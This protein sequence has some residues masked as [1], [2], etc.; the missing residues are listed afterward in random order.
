MTPGSMSATGALI[1]QATTPRARRRRSEAR[2]KLAG[3]AVAYLRVSTEEQ[4]VSGLGLDAQREA[5]EAVAASRGLTIVEWRT[6]AGVSG[7]TIGKRP[8]FLDALRDL[9]EGRAGVLLSK[10]ATRL[11][12]SLTDLG[13][14]LAAATRDGWAVITADGLVDT[15]DPKGRLLPMFLGIVGELERTF[16]QQRTKAALQAAKARGVTLGK[17]SLL[18][19]EV[20]S[21]IVREREAGSTW[22]GIADSLNS[23]GVPTGQGGTTWRP[24]SVRAAYVAA[25]R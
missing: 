20:T 8:A 2:G 23:A 13:G 12:R 9:D 17:R 14:L 11:S 5:V 24:S 4:A 16:T 7:A 18:P 1:Q 10:D 21:R 6:D 22:Q 19:S 3:L 25:T 15:T